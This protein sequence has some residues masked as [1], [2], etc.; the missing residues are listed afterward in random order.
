M[1]VTS[2]EEKFIL[3]LTS[4]VN[5][6]LF[7]L[8]TCYLWH[9]FIVSKFHGA[10]EFGVW[11]MTGLITTVRVIVTA[12]DHRKKEDPRT[13]GQKIAWDLLA[14]PIVLL[15]GWLIHLLAVRFPWQLS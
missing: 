12:T 5:V 8:S 1:F 3:F 6:I 15:V 14:S 7:G 10:P 4:I 13:F 2:S 11:Q 9:W